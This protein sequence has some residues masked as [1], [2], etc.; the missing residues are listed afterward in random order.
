MA[1]TESDTV[2]AHVRRL[3]TET[4][5]VL[6]ASAL[7]DLAGTTPAQ[8][9]RALRQL[10]AQGTAVRERGRGSPPQGGRTPDRWTV[11]R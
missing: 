4:P 10:E 9:A 2:R 11:A 8:A 5:T 3:L 1:F 7:A 6:T